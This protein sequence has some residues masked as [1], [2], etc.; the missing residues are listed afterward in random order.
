M[1]CVKSQDTVKIF[2]KRVGEVRVF[3]LVYTMMAIFTGMNFF[4]NST[5][6]NMCPAFCCC[7]A[8]H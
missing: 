7:V 3:A 8:E 2:K 6:D 1:Q 5:Y 4:M